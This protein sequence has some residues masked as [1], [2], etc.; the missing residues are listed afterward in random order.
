MNAYRI[1][2]KGGEWLESTHILALTPQMALWKAFSKYVDHCTERGVYFIAGHFEYHDD[3]LQAMEYPV[4]T[5][6][7]ADGKRSVYPQFEIAEVK[8]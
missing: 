3:D 7:F 6:Q 8:S 1:T 4:I 2:I 5:A